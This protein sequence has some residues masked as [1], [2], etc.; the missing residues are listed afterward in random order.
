MGQRARPGEKVSV[1]F[2]GHHAE[3]AADKLGQWC[4]TLPAGDAGG[5]FDMTIDG[6]NRIAFKDVLVGDVW[7]ASGQSNMEFPMGFVFPWHDGV[8]NYKTEIPAANYPNM[9]LFHVH[10]AHLGFSPG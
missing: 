5:P 3:T 1:D 6:D 7:L 2:R 8:L 10:M 9:R 4:V